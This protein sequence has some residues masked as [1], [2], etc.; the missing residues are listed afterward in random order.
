MKKIIFYGF[1]VVVFLCCFSQTRVYAQD[2]QEKSLQKIDQLEKVKLM[3]YLNLNDETN[4]KLF[5]RRKDFKDRT[6]S[7]YKAM[8]SLVAVLGGFDGKNEKQNPAIRKCVDDY[9]K[10]ELLVMKNRQEFISSLYEVL[11]P[12]Q[13]GKYIVFEKKFK[14]EIQ[15]FIFKNKEKFH[16][17]E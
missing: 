7:Y 17:G 14:R 1:T 13:V 2:R 12:E 15:D 10:L 8:D 3:E 4:L 11:T 5:A 16:K 6:R 9:Q